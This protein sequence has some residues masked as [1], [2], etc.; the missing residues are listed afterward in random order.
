MFENILS[1]FICSTQVCH[2]VEKPATFVSKSI[3]CGVYLFDPAIF[4]CIGKVFQS[5]QDEISKDL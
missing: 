5:N 2:Y 4:D 3:N 1:P